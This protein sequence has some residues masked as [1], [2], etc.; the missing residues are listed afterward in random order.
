MTAAAREERMPRR[1]RPTV[2][3]AA[4]ALAALVPDFAAAHETWLTPASFAVTPGARVRVALTSGMGF[5]K[6]E[7]PIRPERVQRAGFRLGAAADSLGPWRADSVSLAASHAAPRAGLATAWVELGPRDI[8]L[9][10]AQ[11]E[12]YFAE[13][14]ADSTL[15]AQWAARE[16]RMPWKEFYTKHAKTFVAVGEATADSSWR[17]PAGMGVELVPRFSPAAVRAGDVVSIVLLRD[18]RP[19]PNASVG[20]L[21]GPAGRAFAHTNAD[22]VASLTVTRPGP[23]LFFTVL[24]RPAGEH[25]ES[26]FSTLTVNARR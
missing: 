7:S 16:G 5:P 8:A 6:L 24:L 11:V 21:Q 15:R 17:E 26:D 18:G 23:A 12:E 2:F 22:G 25:W 3:A 19:V 4:L 13:I 10:D 20:I 14:G 1:T 9:A